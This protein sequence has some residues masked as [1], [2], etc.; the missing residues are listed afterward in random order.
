MER[1]SHKH[2]LPGAFSIVT[3]LVLGSQ[4]Y[5]DLLCKCLY[6]WTH[7]LKSLKNDLWYSV[8]RT[9]CLVWNT[10]VWCVGCYD[11]VQWRKCGWSVVRKW[12]ISVW[13]K[14]LWVRLD[15]EVQDKGQEFEDKRLVTQII[16]SKV[17]EYSEFSAVIF[18]IYTTFYDTVSDIC[19]IISGNIHHRTVQ[20]KCYLGSFQAI[21]M[22]A[23]LRNFHKFPTHH[24]LTNLI[25]GNPE[26]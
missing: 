26:S 19:T 25:H 9:V 8:P 4:W 21:N 24:E 10:A 23:N 1:Y 15:V 20:M 16:V 3:M 17:Q 7:H 12:K 14:R 18:K 13:W 6:G 2:L 22:L 5:T 11:L